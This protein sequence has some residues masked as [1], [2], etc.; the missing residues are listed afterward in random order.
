MINLPKGV[1]IND[2]LQF[3][4]K[5][6]L[7]SS[8]ILRSYHDG[9]IPL[10]KTN[11]NLPLNKNP[12]DPVTE[13]DL[14]INKLFLDKFIS[15]FP[16]IKWNIITEEN[17][18]DIKIKEFISDWTWLIDP[19]DGTKDFIQKSGEYAVHVALLFKNK[20]ILG[21]VLIPSLHEIWFGV[22]GIGTWKENEGSPLKID[23]QMFP[24]KEAVSVITSKNHNN[25][26]LDI[27][28]NEMNFKNI[29]RMGS[30]GFKICNLLRNKADI[31]I[32][33]SNQTA[34][35]DWD[36]AAP[37]ALMTFAKLNFSYVWG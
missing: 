19:L 18:K 22:E 4:R 34:P 37:Q 27:I 30:I 9:S 33:I 16:S 32:S 1:N 11:D 35:K 31:Y 13:A 12:K 5:T 8:S 7:Q 25:K 26:K 20:P 6:G 3:L 21:M 17:S 36:I 15:F 14:A 24:K 10:H 2:L 29:V 23:L 28:L